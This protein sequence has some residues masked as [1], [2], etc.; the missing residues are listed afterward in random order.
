MSTGLFGQRS[1]GLVT[2][3]GSY[4]RS[5]SYPTHH[6]SYPQTSR[7][8][9]IIPFDGNLSSGAPQTHLRAEAA[10]VCG[11]TCV[12][13]K[14]N[15]PKNVVSP[16]NQ[17]PLE[18]DIDLKNPQ[19]LLDK[20]GKYFNLNEFY[21]TRPGDSSF[22]SCDYLNGRVETIYS[23]VNFDGSVNTVIREINSGNQVF[24]LNFPKVE[25]GWRAEINGKILDTPLPSTMPL[26][27][28]GFFTWGVSAVIKKK[29]EDSLKPPDDD[30]W[31]DIGVERAK[32]TLCIPHDLTCTK[33]FGDSW[34]FSGDHKHIQW[35]APCVGTYMVDISQ[36]CFDHDVQLWCADGA[37][38]IALFNASVAACIIGAVTSKAIEI[39]FSN[40]PSGF[41]GFIFVMT[42]LIAITLWM[43]VV[44]LIGGILYEV[45]ATL[46]ILG[47]DLLTNTDLYGYGR[48]NNSCLCDLG[49]DTV[50]CNNRCRNLCCE[51][52][53]EVKDCA[54]CKWYCTYHPIT[55]KLTGV[56]INKKGKA[57]WV[58]CCQGTVSTVNE[59]GS[60]CGLSKDQARTLCPP[61][62]P[63]IF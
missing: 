5:S 16:S 26:D 18:A 31:H 6:S 53:K 48:L 11:G 55:N 25:N 22:M 12:P 46:A 49:K 59:D 7:Q 40:M 42:C 39:V 57:P 15:I 24:E 45:I 41:G 14:G 56:G 30:D 17:I 61:T 1:L 4:G 62:N 37:F 33:L 3:A 51:L 35:T 44:G 20:Y 8:A 34:P 19:K 27:M 32:N 21:K 23:K 28:F 36:C 60:P 10:A 54:C 58:P 52:G 38:D 9:N 47:Q 13:N 50:D 43:G 63:Y 29:K 2:N